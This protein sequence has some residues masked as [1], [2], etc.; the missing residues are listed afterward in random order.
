MRSLGEIRECAMHFL[1]E[2][3]RMYHRDF[4]LL[5]RNIKMVC[6]KDKNVFFSTL[7]IFVTFNY[8]YCDL[9][10]LM[11]A[12]LLKQ[13]LTGRVEGMDVNEVFLLYA[14][15]LMEIPMAM[16]VLSRLL[17]PKV[18][19]WFNMVASVIKTIVMLLTL[20][21]GHQTNYYLFF[22]TVEIATTTLIFVYAL[23][24]WRTQ[25]KRILV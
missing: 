9:I 15:F 7:W 25:K 5:Y 18:N 23:R 22:A 3:N 6:M 10:G 21:I 14:G 16:I 2:V 11:D 8:L 12:N 20:C 24:W 17:A 1:T 13:Y 19:A 4:I